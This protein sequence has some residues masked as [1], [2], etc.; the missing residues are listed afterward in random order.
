MWP[1]H[2]VCWLH[3]HLA[4]SQSDTVSE[5]HTPPEQVKN[6][7]T[8]RRKLQLQ[9]QLQF[10][11]SFLLL[12]PLPLL[13]AATLCPLRVCL[14]FSLFLSPSLPS[15]Q[16][17]PCDSSHTQCVCSISQT[18]APD[19]IASHW[20]AILILL[21][22]KWTLSNLLFLFVHFFSLLLLNFT[23]QRSPS[24]CNSELICLVLF[25]QSDLSCITIFPRTTTTALLHLLLFI[26]CWRINA[27]LKWRQQTPWHLNT[28]LSAY[29]NS[30]QLPSP[31]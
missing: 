20:F 29:L 5:I 24:T 11:P 26:R 27:L 18:A 8:V 30:S 2:C 17:A 4:H 3:S 28:A 31:F 15:P 7:G 23:H 10:F 6:R 12:L 9:L 21:Y 14:P 19:Q 13:P 25:S 16:V 22:S 1:W